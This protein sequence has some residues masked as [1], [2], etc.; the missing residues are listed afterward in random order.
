MTRTRIILVQHFSIMSVLSLL[1]VCCCNPIPPMSE[2]DIAKEQLTKNA[3]EYKCTR[4]VPYSSDSLC[5]S[6]RSNL[7]LKQFFPNGDYDEYFLSQPS[8]KGQIFWSINPIKVK[9][10]GL[11]MFELTL[12]FPSP[13]YQNSTRKDYILTLN[14][15]SLVLVRVESLRL[16]I[17][18]IYT[19]R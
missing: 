19:R 4:G 9:K 13:P 15:D 17:Q 18:E 3:W 1:A 16:E 12:S 8:V 6:T 2:F 11:T 10:E 5:T 14:K 7:Y